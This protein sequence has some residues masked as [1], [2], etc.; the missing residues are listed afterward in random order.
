MA[1]NILWEGG[2]PITLTAGEVIAQYA[3]VTLES[4]GQIDE[5]D[6]VADQAIG[7]AMEPAAAAGDVI[8]VMTEVGKKVVLVSD[9]NA[10][11][12]PGTVLMPSTT[13]GRVR[14]ATGSGS[15]R[16]AIATTVAANVNGSFVQAIWLGHAGGLV[17]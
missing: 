4:D 9:G 8:P 13:A 12:N 10:Q 5:S 2:T 1:A 3:P 14:A 16:I 6:A 17:P 7:V 11:I 15:A